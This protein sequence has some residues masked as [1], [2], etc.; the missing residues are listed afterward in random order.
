M[1]CV[2]VV[3]LMFLT[4]IGFVEPSLPKT[5]RYAIG[6]SHPSTSTQIARPFDPYTGIVPRDPSFIHYQPSDSSNMHPLSYY[7]PSVYVPP[8][9]PQYYWSPWLPHPP[10]APYAGNLPLMS[11]NHRM[12]S[13]RQT[14]SLEEPTPSLLPATQSVVDPSSL[15]THPSRVSPSSSQGN[16]VPDFASSDSN[17]D[18]NDLQ[19][20]YSD[21]Q[22]DTRPATP[23]NLSHQGLEETDPSCHETIDPSMNPQTSQQ[24]NDSN[25]VNPESVSVPSI[26]TG[27]NQVL[28]DNP[29]VVKQY[30]KYL[31]GYYRGSKLPTYF[32]YPSPSIS[33]FINLLVVH[34]KKEYKNQKQALMTAKMRGNTSEVKHKKEIISINEIGK[35]DS[36]TRFVLIEGDPGVGK[37]TLVWELCKG[38]AEGRLLKERSIVLLVQLREKHMRE[39]VSIQ[40]MLDPFNEYPGICEYIKKTNGEG[41]LMIFDGFDELSDSQ[42]QTTSL[43]MR[44]LGGKSLSRTSFIVTSRPS[45]TGLLP[46]R[47][48]NNLDQHIE[49]I[50]FEE[51]DI[52]R[53]INCKFSNDKAILTAFNAYISSHHFIFTLMYIPLHCALITQLYEVHW[54]EEDNEFAPKTLT[55][56]YTSFICHLLER[57]LEDTPQYKGHKI[58]KISDLPR[59]VHEQLLALAKLAAKGIE[60]KQYVFDN[61]QDKALGLLQKVGEHRNQSSVSYSFL[62]LTLQEFLA[63]FYWSKQ[64][65]NGVQRLFVIGGALPVEDYFK[66][67]RGKAFHWPA[68]H[69]YS[70]LTGAIGTPLEEI[71]DSNQSTKYNYLYLL[72]ESQ[73]VK[74]VASV[75]KNDV[76]ESTIRSYMEAYVTGYSIARSSRSVQWSIILK[77]SGFV[78]N[79]VHG[80]QHAKL[81][82]MGGVI[83]QL[84]IHSGSSDCDVLELLNYL[85]DITNYVKDLKLSYTTELLRYNPSTE[86]KGVFDLVSFYYKCEKKSASELKKFLTKCLLN[87]LTYFKGIKRI[88]LDDISLINSN[89]KATVIDDGTCNIIH[90]GEEY[91]FIN[92]SPMP[93]KDQHVTVTAIERR[94]HSL[95]S[96]E[97]EHFP[98]DNSALR[99]ELQYIIFKSEHDP[100][101]VTVQPHNSD[102]Y[103][104]GIDITL[105]GE[106]EMFIETHWIRI[107]FCYSNHDNANNVLTVPTN[108]SNSPIRILAN[109]DCVEL[110]NYKLKNGNIK[111]KSLRIIGDNEDIQTLTQ[112]A[113]DNNPGLI[114]KRIDK[115]ALQLYATISSDTSE[116]VVHEYHDDGSIEKHTITTRINFANKIIGLLVLKSS[117]VSLSLSGNIPVDCNAIRNLLNRNSTMKEFCLCELYMTEDHVKLISD[118]LSQNEGLEIIAFSNIQRHFSYSSDNYSILLKG[119]LHH[120]TL[121]TLIINDPPVDDLVNIIDT[122]KQLT[123]VVIRDMTYTNQLPTIISAAVNNHHLEEVA[124]CL[125][126]FRNTNDDCSDTLKQL[127]F[128]SNSKLIVRLFVNDKVLETAQSYS[129]DQLIIKTGYECCK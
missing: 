15:L 94:D 55:Q 54:R 82:D 110:L 85:A 17:S 77:K 65:T 51:K 119:L 13:P 43:F 8:Y 38:W 52:K 118:G 34:K 49:V 72:F 26:T 70:G 58:N 107:H 96:Y 129:T 78:K 67:T 92:D 76:V 84:D 117:L 86:P 5:P 24:L 11:S 125:Y 57:Y 4:I 102:Y 97:I 120:N 98:S 9:Q 105:V 124:G 41:L 56:L 53:Y 106:N 45:A 116:H 47:F 89:I 113:I 59:D 16:V 60:D 128:N 115:I 37:T 127:Q 103:N 69:F 33:E 12:I 71:I 63:A 50:G 36:Q 123:H 122:A 48:Y 64:S 28:I 44:L 31:Q 87:Y 19:W 42:Q 91:K 14:Y 20:H 7:S 114:V 10:P 111:I 29:E 1:N 61:I 104:D 27:S 121:R 79:L 83:H 21:M 93:L 88:R 25:Y 74:L 6:P 99:K 73:N 30:N 90:D 68:L 101:T 2:H 80:I 32:K 112:T 66:K 62:H 40:S 18:N 126:R 95:G 23:F 109:N 46:D 81:Q 3:H 39:A 22:F 75:F 100:N 35:G 108:D